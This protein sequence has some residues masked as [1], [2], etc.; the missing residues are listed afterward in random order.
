MRR[1]TRVEYIRYGASRLG[2][3]ELRIMII[4]EWSGVKAS[5]GKP[6]QIGVDQEHHEVRE[7]PCQD[8][9]EIHSEKIGSESEKSSTEQSGAS[10]VVQNDEE[11]RGA[12]RRSGLRRQNKREVEQQRRHM[13][14]ATTED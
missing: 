11:Q 6:R 4:L 10:I 1:E 13:V 7:E 3:T 14:A 2:Q 9:R 5:G 12:R 8:R